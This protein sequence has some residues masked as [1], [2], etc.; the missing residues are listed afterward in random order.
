MIRQPSGR[1]RF[2]SCS[3]TTRHEEIISLNCQTSL[4]GGDSYVPKTAPGVNA[5]DAIT[6]KSATS[7]SSRPLARFGPVI[8][9][10]LGVVLVF[11]AGVLATT[12]LINFD[13]FV[14]VF[15][16]AG[17]VAMLAALLMR[18]WWALLV[19]PIANT[20]GFCGTGLVVFSIEAASHGGPEIREP[21]PLAAGL[22]VAMV[23]WGV[24]PALIGALVGTL[25]WRWWVNRRHSQTTQPSLS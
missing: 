9:R 21:G 16:Y 8:A 3:S 17:V 12:G 20:I 23:L 4:E 19:L 25:A 14:I 7:P 11:L 15:A 18:S 24:L 10:I 2:D 5:S 13:S 6:S 1:G 22:L